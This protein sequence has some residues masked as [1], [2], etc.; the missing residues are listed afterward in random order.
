MTGSGV[1]LA[2]TA[3]AGAALELRP[4]LEES[5]EEI[6][7][8]ASDFQTLA[9]QT[10]ALLAAAASM[11]DCPECAGALIVV[12]EVQPMAEAARVF[13]RDRILGAN[14]ILA[15][16]TAEAA[17]LNQL[18]QLTRAQKAIVRETDMLRVLTNIEVARL[19][20][21][22]AGFEHLALELDDFSQAVSGSI[23]DLTLRTEERRSAVEEIRRALAVEIPRMRRTFAEAEQ[24]LSQA[25]TLIEP[26]V[27]QLSAAP[28]G[29]RGCVEEV[30]EQIAGVVAAIQTH[31]ITRQQI[32]HAGV[33]LET[34]AGTLSS[35]EG[36][37][38]GGITLGRRRA[39]R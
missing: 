9:H 6:E 20:A 27:L 1:G 19:G 13:L 5:R 10:E 2:S 32:E 39:G 34:I 24:S 17:L 15:T 38:E 35:V 29:F 12:A 16:V 14:R 31:D 11:L 25:L 21:V 33:A 3:R 7:A 23:G 26:T 4:L 28:A 36:G 30:A 22:G 8:L 37:T 18:A